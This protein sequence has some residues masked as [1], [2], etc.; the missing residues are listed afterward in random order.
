MQGTQAPSLHTVAWSGQSSL[1]THATQLASVAAV[2]AGHVRMAMRWSHT[3][4]QTLTQFA[5]AD[6]HA[7]TAPLG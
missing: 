4:P 7:P 5:S 2:P 1:I 6:G 3:V